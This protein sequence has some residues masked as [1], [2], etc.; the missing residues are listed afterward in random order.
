MDHMICKLFVQQISRQSN[1]A[2]EKSTLS[3]NLGC[4]IMNDTAV[5]PYVRVAV[6]WD[7]SSENSAF[8]KH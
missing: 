4:V 1:N 2:K 3:E 7:L 8:M 6:R 5:L